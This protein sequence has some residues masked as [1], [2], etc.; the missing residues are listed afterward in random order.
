MIENNSK[1]NFFLSPQVKR[2]YQNNNLYI[3]YNNKINTPK[4]MSNIYENINEP[5]INKDNYYL[6]MTRTMRYNRNINNKIN[7][8]AEEQNK[9]INNYIEILQNQNISLQQ[10][11]KNYKEEILLRDNEIEGYK[12]KV[13]ALLNQVKDKNNDLSIK[14]M[15][16]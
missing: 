6:N 9:N 16:Y 4:N 13:K 5:N 15:L 12:Q 3:N 2:R 1:E 7:Q 10:Y 14:K 8:K 11:I